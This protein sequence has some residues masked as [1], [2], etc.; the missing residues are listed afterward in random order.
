MINLGSFLLNSVL[1]IP[2]S[3]FARGKKKKWALL[4]NRPLFLFLR[5][6]IL[7]TEGSPLR[8]RH[9]FTSSNSWTQGTL[10][11]AKG[12]DLEGRIWK[13]GTTCPQKCL[14]LVQQVVKISNDF[15]VQKYFWNFCSGL[16]RTT[17]RR[18]K[19]NQTHKNQYEQMWDFQ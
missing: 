9:S 8:K 3:C 17:G 6:Q 4:R 14:L 12:C 7:A 11:K 18:K 15:C 1:L 16:G 10:Q 2:L 19:Y 5:D 13:L